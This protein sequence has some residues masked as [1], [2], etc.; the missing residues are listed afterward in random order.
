[1]AI[2]DVGDSFCRFVTDIGN[3]NIVTNITA[4]EHNCCDSEAFNINHVTISLQQAK[5]DK[6][7]KSHRYLRNVAV[8][9]ISKMN[10]TKPKRFVAFSLFLKILSNSSVMCFKPF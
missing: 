1:M 8:D 3:L 6:N 5:I 9:P 2:F 7:Q 10:R 4:A